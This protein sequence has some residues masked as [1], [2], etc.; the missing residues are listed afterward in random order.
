MEL[1]FY[2]LLIVQLTIINTNV[3]LCTLVAAD[4]CDLRSVCHFLHH[5]QRAD[6]SVRDGP[7]DQQLQR[8]HSVQSHST[9]LVQSRA[10]LHHRPLEPGGTTRMA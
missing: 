2:I 6:Q 4:A 7:G 10:R 9:V 3:Y 1:P 8:A 5:R